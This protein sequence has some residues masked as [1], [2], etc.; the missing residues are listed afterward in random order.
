MDP[1]RRVQVTV[2]DWWEAGHPVPD[3]DLRS[4]D[5]RETQLVLLLGLGV[6]MFVWMRLRPVS[7]TTRRPV[8]PVRERKH[9]STPTIE[10][11][12][13]WLKPP[14][15]AM[16]FGHILASLR[17]LPHVIVFG[18]PGS[19]KSTFMRLRILDPVV[20]L[21]GLVILLLWALTG[22]RW[23]NRKR[24]AKLVITGNFSAPFR[25]A[26]LWLIEHGFPAHIWTPNPTPGEGF[27]LD[28]LE[29]PPE[30]VAE[31]LIAMQ[32]V[33]A[34]NTGLQSGA[35]E[36]MLVDTCYTLQR[37]NEVRTFETILG[38]MPTVGVR[39]L[40]YEGRPVGEPHPLT[41]NELAGLENWSTRM[42]TL[43]RRLGASVGQDLRLSEALA[44]GEAILIEGSS[45]NNPNSIEPLMNL[46]TY[47]AMWLVGAVHNF[48]LII[49][50]PGAVGP[51]V[52]TRLLTATRAWD[53]RIMI[54]MQSRKQVDDQLREMCAT[55]LLLGASG[56]APEAREFESKVVGGDVP[57]E[58]FVLLEPPRWYE[59]LLFWVKRRGLRSCEGYFFS[60]GRVDKVSTKHCDLSILKRWP[61]GSIPTVPCI[62]PSAFT[63]GAVWEVIEVASGQDGWTADQKPL[64]AL[65][66][67][68][69]GAIPL[70]GANVVPAWIAGNKDRERV[71]G[72]L[73]GTWDFSGCHRWE[74]KS[75]NRGYGKTSYI[76]GMTW[77]THYLAWV[78]RVLW[79][80]SRGEQSDLDDFCQEHP[81]IQGPYFAL[82]A[83]LDELEELRAIQFWMRKYELEIDHRCPGFPNPLCANWRHLKLCTKVE[84]LE[85]RWKR[86][87]PG[88]R[89]EPLDV[90]DAEEVTA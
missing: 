41:R 88:Y 80:R 56:G 9:G 54:G 30:N 53:V 21:P 16:P 90:L 11:F 66:E 19:G 58:D 83:A 33:A 23:P 64:L 17:W 65:P 28:V 45:Y 18:G 4:V 39:D 73:K 12:L 52:F 69:A 32:P 15:D 63:K 44:K 2:R 61:R 42:R 62:V 7:S 82:K 13:S 51:S 50:E 60:N 40:D 6:F 22:N 75:R 76:S 55:V 27:G 74:E 3:V 77:S 31:R 70:P 84:N 25:A 47:T 43:R 29:G 71:W 36:G 78:W 49:D 79:Q 37:N 86:R 35:V 5:Q 87:R 46:F 8:V 14:P 48:D 89:D 38:T 26:I 20:G 10:R 72:K 85:L 24:R 1:F 68:I 57:P 67:R 59:I 81:E 34:G